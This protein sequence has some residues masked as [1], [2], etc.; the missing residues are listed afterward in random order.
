MDDTVGRMKAYREQAGVDW[1]QFESPHSVGEIKAARA[2]IE[3][4]FSFMR[5]KLGRYLSL[6][7]VPGLSG[8]MHPVVAAYGL[9]Q[10][11]DGPLNI[12]AGTQDMWVKLCGLLGL[13]GL[14]TDPRFLQN[15]QRMQNRDAMKALIEAKLSRP[16]R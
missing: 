9:F 11:A 2:A 8:N 1:V 6:G 15:E 10:A 4:P 16:G 13:E 12:A 14:A 5:G 7:E 3:G